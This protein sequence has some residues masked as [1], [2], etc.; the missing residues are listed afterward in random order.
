[1]AR[2]GPRHE[3]NGSI[4]ITSPLCLPGPGDI[5]REEIFS[6]LGYSPTPAQLE[7]LN[8]THPTQLVAGGYRGGKSRTASMKGLLS[9]LQFIAR[10]R[11][12]AA[13]HVAWLV[14]AD[15]EATRAE[16]MHPDGSLSRDLQRL[17]PGVDFSSRVD[18][19]EIRVPVPSTSGA[20]SSGYFTIRTKSAFDPTALGMESPVWIVLCEAARVSQD[21]YHRLLSRCSE[22]RRRFPGFGWLHMEG[23]FEGS[24]GWYATLWTRW[25]SPA[26]QEREDAR[27]FSLPSHSNIALFPGGEDDPQITALRRALPE[28]R[29]MERHLGVPVPP[30]GR[31]HAA[32]SNALH[33]RRLVYDPGQP[34]YIGIDP[35]YSGQPST[36][37]VEVCQFRKFENGHR[38]WRVVDEIAVNR[39]TMPGFTVADVCDMAMSRPW[40]Q[41]SHKIGVIDVA[42][43]AHAGAQESNAEVWRKR[44]GLHLMHEKVSILPGIDRFDTC[45]KV[46]EQS[47]EPGLLIDPS[48]ELLISELGGGPNPFDGQSHVYRWNTDRTGD[49]VGRTPRDEYCDGI[50]ALTYLF[51]HVMGY[52]G[53]EVAGWSEEKIRVR[54]RRRNG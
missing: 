35:G 33:V 16:F 1:M 37:A 28:P 12:R 48:C 41:N 32:F 29:F 44:T 22:A 45:L 27:S 36:Y 13:G 20:D 46:D 25:Q 38:Q 23:T 17:W 54:S 42:G 52:A 6:A 47:S 40:W 19:G 43:T 11:E 21:V 30:S 2:H 3:T 14:A 8:D 18:P 49:V 24:L 53:R 10:Y 51:V 5:T 39:H 26:V 9:T 7:I 50:K 34:V 31:V 15:Y 4:E